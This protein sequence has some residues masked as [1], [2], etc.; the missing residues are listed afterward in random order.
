TQTGTLLRRTRDSLV[1]LMPLGV[2]GGGNAT[3]IVVTYV[4]G[5]TVTLPLATQ[6]VTTG[7]RWAPGDTG[8]ASA[9]TLATP[10]VPGQ[11]LQYLTQLPSVSNDADCAEGTAGGGLGKCTIFAYTANGTDSLQ[12]TVDWTP[13]TNATTDNSDIDIYSCNSTGVDG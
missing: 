5:L 4:P 6:P 1:Y 7:D 13:A 10:T 9:P 3:N 12:F 2:T 8:Y 11:S